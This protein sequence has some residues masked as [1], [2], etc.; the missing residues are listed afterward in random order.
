MKSKVRRIDQRGAR[1]IKILYKYAIHCGEQA[2]R[3]LCHLCIPM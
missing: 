3:R 2:T 1:P